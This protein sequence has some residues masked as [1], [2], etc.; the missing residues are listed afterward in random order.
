MLKDKLYRKLMLGQFDSLN[1]DEKAFLLDLV[2]KAEEPIRLKEDENRKKKG[3]GSLAIY[4]T[5]FKIDSI[6]GLNQQV[7][8]SFS[9]YVEEVKLSPHLVNTLLLH[10]QRDLP[11]TM[12]A[13]FLEAI[14]TNSPIKISIHRFA[15]LLQKTATPHLIGFE[16]NLRIQDREVYFIHQENID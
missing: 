2:F 11:S 9:S 13:D 16:L 8:D 15:D 5:G 14:A 12:L 6:V 3:Y 10:K 4:S 1:S 7:L